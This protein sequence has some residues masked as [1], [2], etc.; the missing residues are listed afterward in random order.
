MDARYIIR[1][2]LI[3]LQ[4]DNIRSIGMAIPDDSVG[5]DEIS[6]SRLILD[7]LR[8]TSGE[9]IQFTLLGDVFP[10]SNVYFTVKHDSGLSEENLRKILLNYLENGNGKPMHVNNTLELVYSGQPSEDPWIREEDLNLKACF[11]CDRIFILKKSKDHEVDYGILI[12]E[13]KINLKL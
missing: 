2:D 11:T 12:K 7:Y 1:T 13:S 4:N 9:T 10:I 6:V 5:K 3:L 8:V